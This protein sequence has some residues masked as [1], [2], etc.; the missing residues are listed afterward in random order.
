MFRFVFP[1]ITAILATA[2]ANPAWSTGLNDLKPC[3]TRH[4]SAK[5]MRSQ[6]NQNVTTLALEI[7]A[8]DKSIMLSGTNRK[9][10]F[11]YDFYSCYENT[12]SDTTTPA[13]MTFEAESQLWI[14][15]R[16]DG[17][18]VIKTRNTILSDIG[19]T[20]FEYGD[21]DEQNGHYAFYLEEARHSALIGTGPFFSYRLYLAKAGACREIEE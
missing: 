9:G 20:N 8:T 7:D 21:E 15:E 2:L 11:G 4:Y 17:S 10:Q 12:G 19:G 5:H 14:K 1:I 3:Y 16:S 13:C 18:I 6:P